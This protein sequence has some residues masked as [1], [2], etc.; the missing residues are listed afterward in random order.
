MDLIK[1]RDWV[2]GIE[3][4]WLR[5]GTR[6]LDPKPLGYI[7]FRKVLEYHI[8]WRVLKQVSAAWSARTLPSRNFSG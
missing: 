6:G 1:K 5:I 2:V 3:L 8:K 7:T 4:I